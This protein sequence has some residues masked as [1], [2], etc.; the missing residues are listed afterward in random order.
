VD[1]LVKYQVSD[2]VAGED[3]QRATT[4]RARGIGDGMPMTSTKLMFLGILIMLAGFAL[5]STVMYIVTVRVVSLDA[6][7]NLS[8][9]AVAFFVVGFVVGVVGFFRR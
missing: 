4:V 3:H 2:V 6:A 8:Y 5:N 7:L 9:I 1:E